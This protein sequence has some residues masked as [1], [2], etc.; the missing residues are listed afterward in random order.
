MIGLSYTPDSGSPVYNVLFRDFTSR[1][2]PRTYLSNA[3]FSNSANGTV[4]LDG[5]AFRQKYAWAIDCQLSKADA[6]ELKALFEAWDT[7]RSNGLPVACGISDQTFGDQIDTSALITTPPSF[8]YFSRNLVIV[9]IG[10]TE[11]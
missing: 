11:V 6:L 2:L 4:I 8:T 5:P 1:E 9:N 3:A 10:L 7:D